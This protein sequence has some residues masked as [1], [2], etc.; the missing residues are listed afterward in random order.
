LRSDPTRKAIFDLAHLTGLSDEPSRALFVSPR[1]LYL[2]QN[3]VTSDVTDPRRYAIQF[4][5]YGQYE[6]VTEEDEEDY[7]LFLAVANQAQLE[8]IDMVPY[9]IST[10]EIVR[11]TSTPGVNGDYELSTL[12]VPE[13][14]LWQ[15]LSISAVCS[16]NSPTSIQIRARNSDGYAVF[17][18]RENS[19][20]SGFPVVWTGLCMLGHNGYVDCRITGVTA[21][22]TLTLTVNFAYLLR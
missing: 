7:A 15:A 6:I 10:T 20:A 22:S 17:L 13:G 9:G 21:G 1:T 8:V 3:L 16:G 18:K 12:D 4:Y 2:L 11:V 14:E 5:D 19:P